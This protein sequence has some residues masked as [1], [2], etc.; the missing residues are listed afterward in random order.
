MERHVDQIINASS[1]IFL[2]NNPNSKESDTGNFRKEIAMMKQGNFPLVQPSTT[3]GQLVQPVDFH[4]LNSL[5][6][7]PTDFHD[8]DYSSPKSTDSN[9]MLQKPSI[10]TSSLAD[11]V[12]FFETDF[13]TFPQVLRRFSRYRRALD[14]L[15]Y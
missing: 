2:V 4:D 9:S 5:G 14:R 13:S 1:E 12:E 11:A 10:S 3:S 6:P 15:K 8:S 7:I